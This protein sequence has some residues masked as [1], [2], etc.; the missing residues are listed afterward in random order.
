ME[1]ET[2]KLVRRLCSEAGSNMENAS[3]IGIFTSDDP[4][5]LRTAVDQLSAEIATMRAVVIAA[6]AMLDQSD[7]LILAQFHGR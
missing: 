5:K 1:E 4:G 7:I 2:I 3:P 6:S